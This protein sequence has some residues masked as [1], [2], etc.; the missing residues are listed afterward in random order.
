MSSFEK[1][2]RELK[3]AEKAVEKARRREERRATGRAE[4]EI[5]SR[6]SIVGEVRSAEEV[7]QA[8]HAK[9][10]SA[11]LA[12]RIPVKFFVGSLSDGTTSE[13]LR[14]HFAEDFDID[15]AVVITHRGTSASRNFGFVTA[16]D[17]KDA[18]AIIQALHGSELDGA[19]IVVRVATDRR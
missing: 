12:A 7:L 6:E 15:E 1:R 3:R 9:P 14:A 19:E 2:A 18:P 16:T 4:P 17:R 11:R 5:V 8:L 10:D 13:L